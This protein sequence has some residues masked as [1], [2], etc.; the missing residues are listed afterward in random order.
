MNG[1][2]SNILS[3]PEAILQAQQFS[4]RLWQ[5]SDKLI[6]DTEALKR[7]GITPQRIAMYLATEHPSIKLVG[8]LLQL[9]PD[10]RVPVLTGDG[11][12]SLEQ[13]RMALQP[14]ERLQH[15]PELRQALAQAMPSWFPLAAQPSKIPG[16]EV[17]LLAPSSWTGEE[18]VIFRQLEMLIRHLQAQGLIRVYHQL[19]TNVWPNSMVNSGQMVLLVATP[20]LLNSAFLKHW[21]PRLTER[22]LT[23][24]LRIVPILIS[25][26][27][28]E[29]TALASLV[30]LPLD[31]IA[32]LEHPQRESTW[33]QVESGLKRSIKQLMA[34]QKSAIPAPNDQASNQSCYRVTALYAEADRHLFE[35]LKP[36]TSALQRSGRMDLWHTG[37]LVAG[38][39]IDEELRR[40]VREAHVIL[41]LLSADFLTS[42]RL[43]ELAALALERHKAG[44]A[45][46]L[47]VLLR[48]IAMS[49]TPYAE[50]QCVPPKPVVAFPLQDEAWIEVVQA[51]QSLLPQRSFIS[52]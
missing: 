49:T 36:H 42:E 39:R 38:E 43:S 2:S 5:D 20:A 26:V 34:Q 14:I 50:Y 24:G 33:R 8:V 6:R 3:R 47:Q 7:Q 9:P 48:P 46:V 22:M 32:L 4:K 1:L 23:E 13:A 44:H 40:H 27:E 11:D 15:D 19:H 31:G 51:L 25:H 41:L 30:P 17:V 52:P 35:Q 21:L 45:H 18:A 12:L 16:I 10:K 29:D 37:L 28:W